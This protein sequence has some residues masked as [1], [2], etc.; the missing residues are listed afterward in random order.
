MSK[1]IYPIWSAEKQSNG[2]WGV[3]DRKARAFV[4]TNGGR[5][6]CMQ[7]AKLLNETYETVQ[8]YQKGH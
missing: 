5:N 4:L 3:L 1:T 6:K 8:N 7:I 2:R